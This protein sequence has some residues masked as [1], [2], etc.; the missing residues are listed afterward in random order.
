MSQKEIKSPAFKSTNQNH[1]HGER[2]IE[3]PNTESKA[4]IRFVTREEKIR[5]ASRPLYLKRYE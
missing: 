5:E 4:I 3:L 1:E 2:Q